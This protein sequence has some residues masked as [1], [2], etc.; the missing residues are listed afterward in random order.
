MTTS[1]FR[2]AYLLPRKRATAAVWEGSENRELS[3]YSM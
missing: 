2:P 1:I 3:R